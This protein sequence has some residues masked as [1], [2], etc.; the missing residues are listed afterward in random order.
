MNTLK[1]IGVASGF[2]AKDQRCEGGPMVIRQ[3]GVL[4]AY[5]SHHIDWLE[6]LKPAAELINPIDV[7]AE[8]ST[9]LAQHTFHLTKTQQQ[10]AVLGGD[11]SIAIGTWS[12]AR[13]GLDKNQA[14]GLIWVD[15][16]MDSHTADTSP[17]GAVHGM[18]LAVL[19]GYGDHKF[20]TIGT[21]QTKLLPQHVCL[22]G[23][24]S[25]ESGEATLLERLGVRIFGMREVQ[26]RGLE[27]VM[28]EA[29]A[30]A[31]TGTAGFGVTIDLDGID[32]S[33]APGIGSPA[34]DGLIATDLLTALRQIFGHPR[35]L[36][37]EIA[38][39]N[40]VKDIDQRTAMLAAKLLYA[41]IKINN[42]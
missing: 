28:S 26:L 35:L 42:V 30:I 6:I 23:V 39:Y 33:D 1:I 11:H 34:A 22:I 2:G 36:G 17:S 19:L 18:P 15:A 7:I 27:Q 13:A 9:R 41:M 16:H 37:V 25:Y 40:P 14:L 12:G 8:L 3:S 20:T 31:S 24:R 29:I 38:E 4:E 5:F 32:P 10:F 21:A